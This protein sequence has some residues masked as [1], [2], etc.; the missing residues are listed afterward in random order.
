MNLPTALLAS[1]CQR[2]EEILSIHVVQVN[3]LPTVATAHHVVHRP[4]ILDP[5]LPRHELKCVNQNS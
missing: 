3:I 5:N 4:G 1:L 2:L